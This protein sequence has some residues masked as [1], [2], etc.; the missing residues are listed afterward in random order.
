MP[1]VP[2]SSII[3]VQC[4][5]CNGDVVIEEL[6]CKIF[7]HGVFKKNGKQINPHA[8]KSECDALVE[9]DLI[10]GCGKPFIVQQNDSVYKAIVCDYI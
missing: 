8:P 3:I 6:N 10:H 9:K 7:R 2:V 5:H 4:P 1:V